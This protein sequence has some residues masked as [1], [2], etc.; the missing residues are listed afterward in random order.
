MHWPAF[1]QTS[2]RRACTQTW[3]NGNT[4][5]KGR[6]HTRISTTGLPCRLRSW[7]I[8]GPPTLR[9]KSPAKFDMAQKRSNS[10]LHWE[11]SF[12]APLCPHNCVKDV[13]C[14]SHT[15]R[16]MHAAMSGR[17]MSGRLQCH[18]FE[19]ILSDFRSTAGCRVRGPDTIWRKLCNALEPLQMAEDSTEGTALMLSHRFQD[20]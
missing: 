11:T 17:L 13:H 8:A 19:I 16:A 10:C 2:S 18:P 14:N 5:Y 20:S 4:W 12:G 1:R 15:L 3:R 6:I 9:D 7:S